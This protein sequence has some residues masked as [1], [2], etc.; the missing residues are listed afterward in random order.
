MLILDVSPGQSVK[1]GDNVIITVKKKTGQVCRLAID[2]EKTVPIH[3]LDEE[4][5]M[6]V[7]GITGRKSN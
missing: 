2:A 1:I 4:R 6:G 5:P 7:V 3:H